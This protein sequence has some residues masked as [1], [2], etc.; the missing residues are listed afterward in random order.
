MSKALK[1][2]KPL[3][4]KINKN[5]FILVLE[6]PKENDVKNTKITSANKLSEY[7]KD[8][9][10]KIRLFEEVLGNGKYKTTR[11]IRNRLKIIFYSK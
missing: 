6:N 7:L 4:A 11:L 1:S 9:E 3:N 5:F 10:L 2:D 8:E